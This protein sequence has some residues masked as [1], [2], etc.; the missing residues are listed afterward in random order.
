MRDRRPDLWRRM[1]AAVAAGRL[2]PVGGMRVEA[3]TT[4]SGGE[5]LVR[6]LVH[7]ERFFLDELGVE[8]EEVWLPDSFGYSA[9]LP[10]LVTLSR[11][12]WLLTQE[13]SWS[14]FNRFPHHTFWW[15]GLDGSR[16]F[17]HFPPV[18]TYN[19]ELS[20][21]E[22][23]HLVR[24]FA[25]KGRAHRSLVPFGWGDGGGPTREMLGRAARLR[26]LEG[27]ARVE[28][29]APARFFEQALAEY[30]D[31][32]V[33]VGELYLELHRG[34][35][36]SQAANK[37]GNR[38]AESL[39]REAELWSATA[40]V[41]TGHPYPYDALDRIW[42]RVLL[43]QFHDILPGSSIAWVHR[44]SR[45][46]YRRALAELEEIVAAA[47]QALAGSGED[48]LVFNAAPHARGG[49]P[50]GGAGPR[51]PPSRWRSPSTAPGTCS[52]TRWCAPR[53]TGGACWCRSSTR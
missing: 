14:Q 51:S 18:D 52:T 45:A 28:I 19:T 5:A 50:V 11:S 26:D 15:E 7:G 35:F 27:S 2:V 16:V 39:L 38:R 3:D 40:A 24:S 8:T 23:G 43:H 9:A 4:M 30:P 37:Q 46:T 42:R 17:T 31:A 41:R 32:P 49:V 53:W 47:Q 48:E 34:T 12:R 33:W 20:G 44:E 6:Q 1:T 25:E 13:I 36:T 21:H 29:E 10:Q 22:M